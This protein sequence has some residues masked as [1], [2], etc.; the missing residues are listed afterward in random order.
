MAMA[1]LQ[2]AFVNPLLLAFTVSTDDT[3]ENRHA[4]LKK[5]I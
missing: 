5:L 3:R 1:F 2:A 4:L